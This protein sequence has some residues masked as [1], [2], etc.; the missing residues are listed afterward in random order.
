MRALIKYLAGRRLIRL[1]PGGP[2]AL[3]VLRW[4][5]RRRESTATP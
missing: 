3:L 1:L 4:L 2:A 5:R